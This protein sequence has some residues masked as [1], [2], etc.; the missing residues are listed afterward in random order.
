MP[1]SHKHHSGELGIDCRYC[2]QQVETL[3]TAGLPPTWTCMTCHSQIWTGPDA[4]P[5]ARQPGQNKPLMWARLNRLP[6]YVYFN[7][8]IH[9][10]KGVGCSSCHGAV[11]TMQ[12]TYK[13][14]AFKMEFCVNCHRDPEKFV[15]P[16]GG[17][18]HGVVPP[19]RS[20]QAR[21]RSRGAAPHR[22][23]RTAHRL[24]DLSPL[25][26]APHDIAALRAHL[27]SGGGPALWRSLEAVAETP[28]FRD[29]LAQ[30]FPAAVP[31]GRRARSPPVLPADGGLLRNGGPCG[32]FR[33]RAPPRE[34]PYVR[35]PERIEPGAPLFYTSAAL[36]DGFANGIT[37]LTRDGRPLKIEGNAQHPWSRGGTDISAGLDPRPLR[38][39]PLAGRALLDRI[40]NWQAFRGAMVGISR[41]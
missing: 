18:E 24:L 35:N 13:A 1:F 37:V 30:E 9:V 21:S 36:L 23:R 16:N 19:C 28:A 25:M 12:L 15:R 33:R 31:A 20:G 4:G 8:S 7:H 5:G 39:V 27:A 29:F 40:S 26:P 2:H 3:A 17:V 6:Y 34:V 11:D 14:N 10:T 38:S 22:G 41:R 32:L